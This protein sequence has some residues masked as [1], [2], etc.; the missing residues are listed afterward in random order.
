MERLD[1]RW[2]LVLRGM[3][4]RMLLL[5][6]LATCSGSLLE[7][8][9]QRFA[10]AIPAMEGPFTMGIFSEQGKLVRLLYRD[11]AVETIPSGLNGLI[12]T[13]DGKDDLGND[14]PAGSYRARGL[15]HGPIHISALP[16]YD[17]I[18]VP[19]ISEE[20]PAHPFPV[21]RIVLR[22]AEDELLD[23]RP[24]ISLR[25]VKRTGSVDLEADGLPLV[26]IPLM[27]GPAPT[28]VFCNHGAR[29][30]AAILGAER[31]N[32]RENYLVNGL[33][34]IVPMDAGKLE[35]S[36]KAPAGATDASHP[37]ANAGESAP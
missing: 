17:P 27:E 24:L 29:A 5:G 11:A 32:F 10:V 13:W 4:L 35:V 12:M 22:A 34:Q 1:M 28:R 15:V 19:P 3:H 6:F 36:A 7:A 8:A 23:S 33:E 30:G 21:D 14:V 2:Q 37:A 16:F 9:P 26:T 31:G 18:T 25:A 20:D